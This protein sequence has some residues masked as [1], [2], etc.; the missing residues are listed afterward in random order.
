[1]LVRTPEWSSFAVYIYCCN[2]SQCCASKWLRT[3]FSREKY[4]CQY[5]YIYGNKFVISFTGI[6][7]MKYTIWFSQIVS[8]DV[9]W[10]LYLWSTCSSI[11]IWFEKFRRGMMCAY[12]LF[13]Q[14]CWHQWQTRVLWTWMLADIFFLLIPKTK[15]KLNN[16]SD[17]LL[18]EAI[19]L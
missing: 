7:Y 18:N 3:S 5:I 19:D 14:S 8:V 4:V 12:Y 2:Y 6:K 15:V 9:S 13:Q 11:Q 1:M 17:F 16:M 10:I